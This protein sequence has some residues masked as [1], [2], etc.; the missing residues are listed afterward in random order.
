MT[1]RIYTD[2]IRDVIEALEKCLKFTEGMQFS[3]FAE[4]ELCLYANI[5]KL[6]IYSIFYSTNPRTETNTLIITVS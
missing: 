1:H 6:F 3:G 5:K 2:Y 4:D